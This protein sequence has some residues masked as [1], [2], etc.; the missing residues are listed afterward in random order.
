MGAYQG[1]CLEN[2]GN[3]EKPYAMMRNLLFKRVFDILLSILGLIASSPLWIIISLAIYLEDG[4]P[5]FFSLTLPGRFDKPFSCLKFRTMKHLKEGRHEMVFLEEDPRVTKVGRILR[6]TALDELPQLINIFKGDMSFVGP[7][8]VNRSEG[9]P[10]YVDISQ[11]PG[12]EIRR[13]V[14]PGLTGIA[15][16]YADKYIS[17]RSKFRYDNVYVRNTG[18]LLD[19]K[20]V[21]FSF[22]VTIRGSWERRGRKVALRP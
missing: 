8:P 18:F 16:L 9:N 5:I 11:V 21:L 13:R 1:I 7:R 4:G 12:Y 22:W 10:R 2:T 14:R 19:L 15:Q 17:P 6:A 20:I 3:N